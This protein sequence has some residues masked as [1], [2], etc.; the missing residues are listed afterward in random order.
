M[1]ERV[2]F[3]VQYSE[4]EF[5][6]GMMHNQVR[7]DRN[8]FSIIIT[9]V[10][11]I[12]SFGFI[13]WY[14]REEGPFRSSDLV[15][16]IVILAISVP[17]SIGIDRFKPDTESQLSKFY[18]ENLI[19]KETY[20]VTIDTEGIDSRSISLHN[21]VRWEAFLEAFESD[22]DF[23]FLLS[24]QQPLFFPKRAFTPEQMAEVRRIA[25]EMMG[26][27]AKFLR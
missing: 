9:A 26:L 18:R 19:L 12:A 23:F 8:W 27:R 25:S 7:A 15:W 11:F 16:A 1:S 2:Q 20:H 24:Q 5:V 10:S 14:G 13:Y 4:W 21:K 6:R 17:V 22:D 3:E